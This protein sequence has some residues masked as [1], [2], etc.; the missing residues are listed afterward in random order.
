[1]GMGKIQKLQAA[2][3]DND[4]HYVTADK[5]DIGHSARVRDD[6]SKLSYGANVQAR[7]P[8]AIK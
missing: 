8:A 1:M 4:P 7:L 3:W 5:G 2:G 6:Y